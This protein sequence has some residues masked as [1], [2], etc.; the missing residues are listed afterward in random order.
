MSAKPE[1]QPGF[2]DDFWGDEPGIF[3]EVDEADEEAAMARVEADFA[4]GRV[5]PHAL[6]DEWLS[7]VGTPQ[8]TPMPK[9][10]LK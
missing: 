1:A 9:E 3:D 2:D 8:A 6:V 7:R 5:I 4:A 10:W